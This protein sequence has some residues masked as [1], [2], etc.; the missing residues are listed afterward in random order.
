M[1]ADWTDFHGSERPNPREPWRPKLVQETT[2]N[3][4]EICVDLLN[5][6]SSAFYCSHLAEQLQN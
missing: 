2:K 5:P 1:N 6:C 3:G 4:L